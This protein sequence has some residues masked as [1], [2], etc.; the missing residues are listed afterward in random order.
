MRTAVP[1]AAE[2]GTTSTV[3]QEWP[4]L[5]F[6]MRTAAATPTRLAFREQL[7]AEPA[8]SHY[9]KIKKHCFTMT[10]DELIERS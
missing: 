6:T 8:K 10:Y 2:I 5:R 4:W 1:A 9:V 7:I 3:R